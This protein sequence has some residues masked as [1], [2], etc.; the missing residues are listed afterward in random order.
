MARFLPYYR[1]EA[2]V[3]LGADYDYPQLVIQRLRH[4]LLVCPTLGSR[5]GTPHLA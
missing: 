2:N 1:S 4:R 3:C 5:L